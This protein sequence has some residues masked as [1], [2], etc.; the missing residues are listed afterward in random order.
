MKTLNFGGQGAFLSLV[1]ML[2]AAVSGSVVSFPN[3]GQPAKKGRLTMRDLG[4]MFV[5]HDAANGDIA[6]VYDPGDV[7]KL[8]EDKAIS[9][10]VEVN[11]EAGY[12][13][14]TGEKPVLYYVVGLYKGR[15][16]EAMESYEVKGIGLGL[17]LGRVFE[18]GIPATA[19][20]LV[21]AISCA[22]VANGT[23]VADGCDV[24]GA[25]ATSCGVSSGTSAAASMLGTGGGGGN[26]QGCSIGCAQGHYACC[27]Y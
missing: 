8:K 19:D 20:D 27:N 21:A 2:L 23:A 5:L 24:G 4:N 22:C 13:K 7:L 6:Y 10:P 15:E 1:F 25:S 14:I 3:Y 17:G 16:Y 12:L 18:L 11:A 9:D 26:S